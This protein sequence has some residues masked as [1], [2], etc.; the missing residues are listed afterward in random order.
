MTAF[1]LPE[2]LP[3]TL[4]G[5]LRRCPSLEELSLGTTYSA[6]DT[7]QI[8]VRPLW[9]GRWPRLQTLRL[10]NTYDMTTME[11]RSFISSHPRLRALVFSD[12]LELDTITPGSTI[13]SYSG[14]FQSL[15]HISPLRNL[16]TLR[17][18]ECRIWWEMRSSLQLYLGQLVSLTTLEISINFFLRHDVL[19]AQLYGDKRLQKLAQI[20][21]LSLI[22]ISCPSLLHFTV[23]C[24]ATD[25]QSF[26]MVNM[27]SNYA[28]I[29]RR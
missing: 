11:F 19:I 18:K 25:N 4:W 2:P 22:L 26:S 6:G 13:E 27:P 3:H 12:H 24:S 29:S 16:Q 23:I 17:L 20:S 28:Q 7:R 21:L 1:D 10:K 15:S 9:S 14:V 8:D 5:M